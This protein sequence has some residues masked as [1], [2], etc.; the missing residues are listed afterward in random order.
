MSTANIPGPILA[1]ERLEQ[2]LMA[3]AVG[4]RTSV[5]NVVEATGLSEHQVNRALRQLEE[6]DLLRANETLASGDVRVLDDG[7]AVRDDIEESYERGVLRDAAIRKDLLEFFETETRSDSTSIA[8]D[9]PG[10][11]L[12]PAPTEREV[13]NA[14]DWL[15]QRGLV[16]L[17]RT[18]QGPWISFGIT[19]DG[20]SALSSGDRLIDR[21]EGGSVT[22]NYGSHT[23]NQQNSSIGAQ[24]VGDHNTVTG[25]VISSDVLD[26]IRTKLDEAAQQAQALPGTHRGDVVQAITDAK[27]AASS[28]NP[29]PSMLRTLT[30]AAINAAGTSTAVEVV[31]AVTASLTQVLALIP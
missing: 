30:T 1:S 12:D 31:G 25:T 2:V 28:E 8:A 10:R 18:G 27:T 13:W 20:S 14:G 17:T 4:N 22:H 9:W 15:D 6:L 3:A 11:E 7:F 26:D 16:E 5:D 29:S 24:S 23:F 21:T 19:T